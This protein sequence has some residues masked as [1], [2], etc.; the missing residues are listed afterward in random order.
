MFWKPTEFESLE[1]VFI[2]VFRC[3]TK[4]ERLAFYATGLD[5]TKSEV[6]VGPFLERLVS[7]AVPLS[8]FSLCCRILF[9][10]AQCLVF[11]STLRSDGS[12]PLLLVVSLPLKVVAIARFDRCRG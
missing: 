1:Q 11:S 12:S 6:H 2:D 10:Q 4:L 5:D 3:T 9:M 8:L 7:G